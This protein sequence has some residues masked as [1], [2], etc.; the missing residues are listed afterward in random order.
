MCFGKRM[1][2]KDFYWISFD[3][4]K[5]SPNPEPDWVA[6]RTFKENKSNSVDD[7]YLDTWTSQE[8][9]YRN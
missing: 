9:L 7:I 4:L 8:G 6:M 5:S 3:I 2:L 1:T